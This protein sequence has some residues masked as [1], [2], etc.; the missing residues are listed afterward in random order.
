MIVFLIILVVF[1]IVVC[2]HL[3][4]WCVNE[5]WSQ[6]IPHDFHHWFIALVFLMLVRGSASYK[7][8]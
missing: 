8:S 2:P 6:D 7:K 5:L 4:I 3:L 1:M